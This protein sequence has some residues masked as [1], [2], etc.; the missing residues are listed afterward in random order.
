MAKAKSFFTD[1]EFR[2]AGGKEPLAKFTGKAG[3][4]PTEVEFQTTRGNVLGRVTFFG[5]IGTTVISKGYQLVLR[6]PGTG[7]PTEIHKWNKE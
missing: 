3:S 1:V 7:D 6:F 2:L 4:K 5:E